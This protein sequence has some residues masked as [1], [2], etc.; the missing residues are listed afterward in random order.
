MIAGPVLGIVALAAA[1]RVAH[2]WALAGSAFPKFPLA[3]TESDM[4]AFWQWAQ[5]ILAG[6]WLGRDTYHPYFDWMRQIAA[7]ESWHRWWGG[8]ETFHQ[9]PL[10]PYLLAVMLA[11]SGN[12]PVHVL[13][14]QLLLGTLQVL[15]VYELGRRLGNRRAGLVAAALA[16]LYGPLIFHQGV[17]LRDWLPPILEPLALVLALRADET[18]RG[19]TW[20]LAGGAVGAAA[21]TRETA[22]L[23]VPALGIWLVWRSGRRWR[24]AAR[25]GALA[26]LGLGLA[27]APL[28]ARNAAVGA[29]PL[30]LSISGGMTFV[31]Q[32]TAESLALWP[33]VSL[34]TKA[35]ILRTGDGRTAAVVRE[36]LAT[37]RGDPAALAGKLALRLR[38]IADPFEIPNNVSFAYGRELSWVLRLAPTFAVLFPLGAAG[39]LLSLRD[40]RRHRLLYL[41]LGATLVN[42]LVWMPL[43]RYRLPLAAALM[44]YAGM[45]VVW[46]AGAVGRRAVGPLAAGTAL[47]GGLAL[48][49]HQV[50]AVP[51]LRS[52]VV[53]AVYRG[54]EHRVAAAVYRSEQRFDRAGAEL[55][56]LERRLEA[57]G[58]GARPRELAW[59]YG[60][61]YAALAGLHEQRG[62]LEGAE[63]A[64]VRAIAVAEGLVG[65]DH[66]DLAHPLTMLAAF[67]VRRARAPDG[68][69]EAEEQ[70]RRARALFQRVLALAERQVPR[71]HRLIDRTQNNLAIV[72]A[73]QHR[74]AEAEALYRRVLASRMAR[75]GPEHP[76]VAVVLGNLGLLYLEQGRHAEAESHLGQA[77]VAVEKALGPTHQE[78]VP[79]LESYAAL[80]RRTGRAE[81][82]GHL[83]ARARAIR[84]IPAPL[85]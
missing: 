26:G 80:L 47:V 38:A 48:L 24:S 79:R 74:W 27:L 30:A 19:R 51:L 36:T 78:L 11:V 67:S 53:A 49:Q 29:P 34:D 42:L 41:Y 50:L 75:F 61:L 1:L 10:Y 54:V 83:E 8:K 56:R 43:G 21:L 15:V 73:A 76:E 13:L 81:E 5:A 59:E 63:H 40:W 68:A 7:P 16:A 18:G 69:S 17:M 25:A 66:P 58:P 64:L 84:R 71:D 22:L 20:V 33:S 46:L 62:N 31:D 4:H 32:N 39:L 85:R 82:A 37:Y 60:N 65:P 9:A 55:E 2:F 6:D 44:P 70:W 12:S 14:V 77:L 57:I 23:L 72:H 3:F 28:V 52:S 35:R 45:A